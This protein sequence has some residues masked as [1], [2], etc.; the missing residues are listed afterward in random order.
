MKNCKFEIEIK[1]LD[2][3]NVIIFRIVNVS[4]GLGV[5]VVR[6]YVI[7][8]TVNQQWVLNT[9]VLTIHRLEPDYGLQPLGQMTPHQVCVLKQVEFSL[10]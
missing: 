10:S 9:Y 8:N 1:N 2:N 7:D 3:I 4:L 5:N 6:I